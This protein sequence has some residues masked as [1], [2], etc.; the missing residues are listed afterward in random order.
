MLAIIGI[1]NSG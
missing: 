1:K